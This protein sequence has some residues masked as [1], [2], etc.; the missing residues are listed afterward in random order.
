MRKKV[1]VSFLF[2]LI[3]FIFAKMPEHAQASPVSTNSWQ[4][5]WAIKNSDFEDVDIATYGQNAGEKNVWMVDQEGVAAWGTTNPTGKIEVWQAG[6]SQNIP[7]FSGINFI[8]LNSDGIGPV[9]QDIRTIPGSVLTWKFAHRGRDGVDTADL[10]IGTPENQDEVV[11]VSDDNTDWGNYQG[12]YVVPAGQTITRLTFNPISTATGSLSIGNFLDDVEL[13]I[14]IEGAKI[15][16]IV[17]YDFNGDGIQQNNE[18]PAPNIKVELLDDSGAVKQTTMTNNIGSYL[19]TDVLPGDYQV[20]FSLPNDTYIFSKANQG[21]NP[22]INSKADPTGLASVHIPTLRTENFDVDAGITTNG[23]V[24]IQ[25]LSGEKALS[26]AVYSIKDTTGIEVATI[27]TGENGTGSAVGLPP[28][29][30]TATEV[31]APIGYQKKITPESFSIVYGNTDPVKLTFQNVAKTGA[32]SI[33]K[34]DEATQQGLENAVFTV[35]TETEKVIKKVATNAKGYALANNLPPGNYIVKEDIAPEGYEKSN[36]EMHVTIPFNPQASIN[37]T[38]SNT[39]INMIPAPNNTDR[40]EKQDDDTVIQEANSKE[41][42]PQTGDSAERN[43]LFTGIVLVS[44]SI[45]LIC[46]RNT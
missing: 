44:L 3:L 27:T 8:E 6:N 9:Y 2:I 43:V 23:K 19:F 40:A 17:W 37:I 26:G 46:R 42:L 13:Y 18:E 1:V 20:K 25:K 35:E 21:N 4:L 22:E 32:I 5:K 31:T 38:F 41:S 14:N 7:P 33:F 11:R 29:T 30:Y 16:D 15:G 36:K 45:S 28:G 34:K 39:K 24:E 10:V 12:N